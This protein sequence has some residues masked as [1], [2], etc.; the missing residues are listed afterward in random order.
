MAVAAHIA[1]SHIGENIDITAAFQT[2]PMI[3]R[4]GFPI[5]NGAFRFRL[6]HQSKA[7]KATWAGERIAK[8]LLYQGLGAL[9]CYLCRLKKIG[10]AYGFQRI[11]SIW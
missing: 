10:Y 8:N 2:V 3:S 1:T 4:L 11:T 7:K 6:L 5:T 9:K